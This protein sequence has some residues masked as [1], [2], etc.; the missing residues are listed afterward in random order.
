MTISDSCAYH[1][2]GEIDEFCS[3][4]YS[5]ELVLRIGAEQKSN[6]ALA[7]VL[8]QLLERSSSNTPSNIESFR[9]AGG[10]SSG[11]PSETLLIEFLASFESSSDFSRLISIT[12]DYGQTLAHLAIPFRCS[13]LLSALIKWG[14]DIS[15]PDANS[16]TPLDFAYLY[17]AQEYIDILL[18][19]GASTALV[20]AT[21]QTPQELGLIEPR[22]DH[23]DKVITLDRTEDVSPRLNIQP[24]VVKRPAPTANLFIPKKVRSCS[25]RPISFA[26]YSASA[27]SPLWKLCPG[28]SPDP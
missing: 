7:Q 12:N 21:V 15:V 17:E 10:D 28:Q 11:G 24:V 13:A 16:F 27:T 20:D 3:P 14:G 23:G 2:P 5:Y 1:L 8:Q 9:S 19:A 22:I 26:D 18:T 6:P 25:L 4:F